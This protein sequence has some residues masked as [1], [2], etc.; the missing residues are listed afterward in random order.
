MK[1]IKMKYFNLI[2][3][4]N[5]KTK[6]IISNMSFENLKKY[7]DATDAKSLNKVLEGSKHSQ[8]EIQ[9]GLYYA[10]LM[11][12]CEGIR[13]L[14]MHGAKATK[15]MWNA[16]IKPTSNKGEGGHTMAGLYIQAIYY[17][18]VSPNTVLSNLK[19]V[20]M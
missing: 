8:A 16:A 9:K 13:V 6:N 14:F 1:N 15:K 4:V 3:S 2:Y 7:I 12:D 18:H 17:G 5:I 10:S 19:I 11:G 20:E